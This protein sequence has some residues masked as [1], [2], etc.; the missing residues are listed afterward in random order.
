[1]KYT[2][3]YRKIRVLT[4]LSLQAFIRNIRLER[5]ME[6]L[7]NSDSSIADIAH[8]VGFEDA[9]YFSRCFKKQFGVSPSDINRA[10]HTA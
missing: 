2:T 6:L 10:G 1:M 8:R 9:N 5:S 7:K 3:L 4:N